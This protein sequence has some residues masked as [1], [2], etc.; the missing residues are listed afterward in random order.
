MRTTELESAR[1]RGLGPT[2]TATTTVTT[3]PAGALRLRLLATSDWRSVAVEACE[4]VFVP[5]GETCIGTDDAWALDNERLAVELRTRELAVE[6]QELLVQDLA[7]QVAALAI[8]SPVS[9]IV[10]HY[11]GAHTPYGPIASGAVSLG[12]ARVG[13]LP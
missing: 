13:C 2:T 7:R 11:A 6:Q 9:G 5:G 4:E 12:T 10:V 8:V 1:G 3:A